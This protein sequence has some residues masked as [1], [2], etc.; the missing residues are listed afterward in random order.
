MEHPE[1]YAHTGFFKKDWNQFDAVIEALTVL[2][3]ANGNRSFSVLQGG[4][5]YKFDAR[6]FGKALGQLKEKCGFGK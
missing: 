2:S 6:D 4:K 3:D 5:S 1:N